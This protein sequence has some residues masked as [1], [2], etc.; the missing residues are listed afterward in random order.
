M[1]EWFYRL[2]SMQIPASGEA[3]AAL[4]TAARVNGF[5]PPALVKL[6]RHGLPRPWPL[7]DLPAQE[8]V[9]GPDPASLLPFEVLINRLPSFTESC[10]RM[11]DRSAPIHFN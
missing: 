8:G 7:E 3:A 4:V 5:D 10:T 2:I 6:N 9:V 11:P 1:Y